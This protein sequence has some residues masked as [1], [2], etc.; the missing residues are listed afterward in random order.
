M[1]L[2]KWLR[3]V[4]TLMSG[5][6]SNIFAVFFAKYYLLP[7]KKR[8]EVEFAKMLNLAV[9]QK[10]L[11]L[12]IFQRTQGWFSTWKNDEADIAIDSFNSDMADEEFVTLLKN[13][14]H[15]K[16]VKRLQ[17]VILRQSL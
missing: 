15:A 7:P 11:V 8:S 14:E 3:Q 17:R 6:G 10:T 9:I 4:P 13:A 1:R 12:L 5:N 2:K 16:N